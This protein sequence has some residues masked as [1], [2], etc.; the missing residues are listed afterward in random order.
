MQ[1]VVKTDWITVVILIGFLLLIK[2][3]LLNGKKK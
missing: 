3:G 1:A 2:R